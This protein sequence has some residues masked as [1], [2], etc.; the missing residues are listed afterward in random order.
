MKMAVFVRIKALHLVLFQ[1]AASSGI[2]V[3]SE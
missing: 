3:L 1:S 2:F